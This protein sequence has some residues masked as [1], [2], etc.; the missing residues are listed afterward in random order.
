MIVDLLVLPNEN[1]GESAHPSAALH[2]CSAHLSAAHTEGRGGLS[3]LPDDYRDDME[4]AP[5]TAHS[6]S[7]NV[8]NVDPAQSAI[9]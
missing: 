9:R 4:G 1:D 7:T 3:H 8:L 2:P 6:D 5:T